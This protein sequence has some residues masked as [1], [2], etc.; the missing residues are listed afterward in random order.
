MVLSLGK[1]EFIIEG[2]QSNFSHAEIY[3]QAYSE[4]K[5]V[6]DGMKLLDFDGID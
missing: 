1:G 6:W 3:A 2:Y 5:T 4:E